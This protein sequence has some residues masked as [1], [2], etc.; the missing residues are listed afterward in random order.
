MAVLIS[1]FMQIKWRG[2]EYVN[3]HCNKRS[4]Y[5]LTLDNR[6][7]FFYCIYCCNFNNT[8]SSIDRKFEFYMKMEEEICKTKQGS[9]LWN[10][11]KATI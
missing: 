5:K 11:I 6:Y 3:Y 1:N 9:E 2:Y 8:L 4:V 7:Y 10:S